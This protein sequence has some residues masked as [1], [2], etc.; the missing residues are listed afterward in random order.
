MERR[1]W[2]CRMRRLI[3][4]CWIACKVM[5]HKRLSLRLDLGW[6]EKSMQA[7]AA[8]YEILLAEDNPSDAV[9]VTE[10]LKQH[11]VSCTLRTAKD[12]AQGRP[13][14]DLLILDMHLPKRDGID[15][16]RRLRSAEKCART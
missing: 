2:W 5:N 1:T 9:L 7:Y 4:D 3:S 13:N 15:V 10:A 16:L 14:L 12:G 6:P 8:K 11:T